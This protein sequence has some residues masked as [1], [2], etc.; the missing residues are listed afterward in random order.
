[1]KYMYLTAILLS[2]AGILFIDY[3]YKLAFFYKAK[4]TA[5]TIVCGLV[6]FLA[7]D[8]LGIWL[9]IFFEGQSS[10]VTGLMLAP[11]LPI[12]ELFFLLFL[13]YF[14]LILYRTLEQ[15]CSRT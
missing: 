15:R 10:Y 7:W 14:T 13:C 11:H 4:Q 3:S 9:G 6:L 5:L 12:E 1:M 8:G 2:F